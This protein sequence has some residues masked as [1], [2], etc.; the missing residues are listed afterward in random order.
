[1][2]VIPVQAAYMGNGYQYQYQ[3]SSPHN[4]YNRSADN[5][6]GYYTSWTSPAPY[7]NGTQCPTVNYRYHNHNG[8]R[9]FVQMP[10][11]VTTLNGAVLFALNNYSQWVMM[12]PNYA[13]GLQV[14]G[15]RIAYVDSGHNLIVRDGVYGQPTWESSNF[16][17]YWVTQTLLVV[18]AGTTLMFKSRLNDPWTLV[19]SNIV[20][21]SVIVTDNSITFTPLLGGYPYGNV[22]YP[23]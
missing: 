22:V 18:R 5:G 10:N 11:I 9:N 19:Q 17:E 3:S 7:V 15:E 2:C 20:P 12:T 23:N 16:D 1:M 13:Y 6:W 4:N 8:N 14:H 21:G